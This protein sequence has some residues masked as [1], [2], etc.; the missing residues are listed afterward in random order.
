MRLI[1]HQQ[2]RATQQHPQTPEAAVCLQIGSTMLYLRE[3]ETVRRLHEV[4]REQR[5][6]MRSLPYSVG[7][8][9]LITVSGK[10]SEPGVVLHAKGEPPAGSLLVPG[11][12]SKA[13]PYIRIHFD[14]I[15]FEARDQESYATTL[16]AVDHAAELAQQTFLEPV[17]L[18]APR[19]GLR[20][21]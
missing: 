19:L 6:R 13:A 11:Q 8:K 14:R 18:P 7:S 21:A 15:A 16:L 4:W 1:G 20:L 5:P 9:G 17:N 3:L 12:G 10:M 2:A